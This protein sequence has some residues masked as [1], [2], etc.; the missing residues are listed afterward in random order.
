MADSAPA[1][2][3]DIAAERAALLR[4]LELPVSGP[5]YRGWIK[6]AAW[7]VLAVLTAQIVATGLRV[8]AESLNQTF[9]LTVLLCYL[10]LAVLTVLMQRSVTTIDARGLHQTW[11]GRR[12]VAW[13]DVHYVKFVPY[14]FGKRLV[15][16][17][18]SGR[19]T[20][21]LAASR[22]VEIAFARIALV[23]RRR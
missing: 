17:N 2:G 12:H 9:T 6:G 10:G 16:F 1:S 11:F 19:F 15:V 7:A 18:R 3:A 5:A 23:Y 13:D 22:P 8:P 14:P 4:E 21:F 20:T